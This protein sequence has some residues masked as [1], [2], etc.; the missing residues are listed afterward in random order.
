VIDTSKLYTEAEWGTVLNLTRI[1]ETA[2]Q[3][4]ASYAEYLQSE[5]IKVKTAITVGPLV[6][7][8]IRIAQEEDVSLIVTGRQKRSI[9]GELFVGSS[10]DRVIRRA[11]VPVLVTK[12]HT[13]KEIEGEV[14][15]E[16]CRNM[17]RKILFPVDWSPWTER[18]KEYFPL[19]RQ[20]G[21]SEVVI[22]HVLEDPLIE[23]KYVTQRTQ[24]MIEERN[25][26]LESPK[27][28]LVGSGFQAKTYLLEGGRAYHA[29]NRIATK[30]DVSM[31]LMG[32]H[33]KG[34][35]EE[36]LW[37]SVSQRVVE[38]SEKPVLVVK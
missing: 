19:L 2:A 6:S 38:Y 11:T 17:F 15:E 12:Y 34:F 18:T 25:R 22:V 5:G 32:S 26:A 9:L 16:F 3:R 7:E 28:E 33:G 10:T 31:I 21:A 13:V 36:T 35:V 37:G 27:Q 24:E 4:L 1:Q 30:E 20:V 8:V 29:I 23:A 14:T